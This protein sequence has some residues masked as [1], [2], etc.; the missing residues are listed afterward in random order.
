MSLDCCIFAVGEV[1]LEAVV[2]GELAGHSAQRQEAV[3]S[4][5]AAWE[6]RCRLGAER[7]L[8]LIA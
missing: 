8:G 4:H 1:G 6:E 7:V 2:A 3:P 5:L